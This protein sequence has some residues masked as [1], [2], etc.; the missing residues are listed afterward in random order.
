M[1]AL[2]STALA[3]LTG[4]ALGVFSRGSD[5]LPR[6]V[7]WVGNLGAVWLGAA[8]IMG[9]HGSRRSW[10]AAMGA[11]ALAV[12]A[13]VHYG[14]YRLARFGS[15]D[16]LRYP[17][18]QWAMT[19]I[20]LGG[21]GGAAGSLWKDKRRRWVAVALMMVVLGAEAFYLG[22]LAGNE[23][24]ARAIA[25]PLEIAAFVLLPIAALPDVRERLRAA[26]LSA[27]IVPLGAL[28]IAWAEQLAKR[29]Y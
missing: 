7:G 6:E 15:P 2:R 18:P 1:S 16:L 11:G 4:I 23:P 28:A 14:S 12:A 24:N 13:A 20:V 29:I 27:S 25:L 5:L 3:V 10:S 26:A 8:L 9:A 17:A 19:G 22:V 21:L